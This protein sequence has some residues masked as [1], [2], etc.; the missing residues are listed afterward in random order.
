MS[1]SRRDEDRPR[2]PTAGSP[3]TTGVS[4]GVAMTP[5][6]LIDCLARILAEEAKRKV[7]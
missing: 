4:S 5:Q 1:E 6:V 7:G 2:P 3:A